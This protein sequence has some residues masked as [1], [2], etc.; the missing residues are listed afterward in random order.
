MAKKTSAGILLYRDHTAPE[1]FLVHP[2]GP[3]WAKKDMGAW[4]LP[5]G[6]FGE[7]EDPLAAAKREFEEETGFP[8]D[9]EFQA[10]EAL[11]QPSGKMIYAWAVKG[12]CDPSQLKSNLFT[13]EWPPKSGQMQEFPEVDRAAWF[14]IQEARNRIIAGQV[15][16]LDQLSSL[17][18]VRNSPEPPTVQPKA[19]GSLF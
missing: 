1:V 12:D 3:F 6:E 18:G 17:L 13:M 5:K 8:I 15:G 19:Q 2:G 4:S 11:R 10:L 16:F 7:G 9:G 14:D